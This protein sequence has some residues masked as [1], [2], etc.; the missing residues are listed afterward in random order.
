MGIAARGTLLAVLVLSW[1]GV[2]PAQ[3]QKAGPPRTVQDDAGFFSDKAKERANSSIAEVK[4][5]FNKDLVIE[6]LAQPPKRPVSIDL[7]DEKAVARFF[8][9]WAQKRFDNQAI[10]GVYVVV[11]EKPTIL[12]V[13]LGDKTRDSGLFTATNREQLLETFQKKLKEGNKDEA[14]IAGATY[15]LDTMVRNAGTIERDKKG[16]EETGAVP[17]AG[18]VN[19][20]DTGRPAWLGW[21]CFAVVA[22]LVIWLVVGLVRSFSGGAGAPGYGYGG[23]GFFSG[24]LGGLFG[25][26]AGMWLYS[27]FFGD[28]TPSAGATPPTDAGSAGS[29]QGTDVGGGSSVSGGDYGDDAGG[30]VGDA[31][32]AG[33]DWGDFGGGDWGG[34]GGDW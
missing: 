31:G 19:E 25:A 28:H 20:Q 33:G 23:G 9:Q 12:R 26:A 3:G 16:R 32:D 29:D 10:N 8:D 13:V 14:L 15:V 30:D 11:L 18:R 4:K 24:L 17:V 1:V 34:G 6:T 27:H 22:V 5:R 2:G 21:V 7:K